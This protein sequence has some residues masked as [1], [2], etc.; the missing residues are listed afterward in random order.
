[1]TVCLHAQG[2]IKRQCVAMTQTRFEDDAPSRGDSRCQQ[3]PRTHTRRQ[4]QHLHMYVRSLIKWHNCPKSLVMASAILA[5]DS[6]MRCIPASSFYCV[7]SPSIGRGGRAMRGR[8]PPTSQ[9]RGTKMPTGKQCAL[10]D[11]ACNEMSHMTSSN[12]TSLLL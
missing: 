10:H 6:V 5:I 7:S 9:Q 11:H 4:T 8:R 1:M 3:R 12:K 2:S